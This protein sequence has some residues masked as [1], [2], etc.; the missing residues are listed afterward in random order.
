MSWIIILIFALLAILIFALLRMGRKL[1]ALLADVKR[2]EDLF[3][4]MVW[5][6]PEGEP[7][8]ESDSPEQ[9]DREDEEKNRKWL[10]GLNNVL[11]YEPGKPG[12]KSE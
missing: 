9:T 2:H 7:E 5:D 3:A 1:A 11:A 6:E 10:E 4:S 8:P 12:K